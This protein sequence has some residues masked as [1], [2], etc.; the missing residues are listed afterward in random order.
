MVARADRNALRALDRLARDEERWESHER[1]KRRSRW[2]IVGVRKGSEGGW[3]WGFSVL[4]I[5]VTL[6]LEAGSCVDAVLARAKRTS[7]CHLK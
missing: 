6:G 5:V 7:A 1:R 4:G 2:A 3:V